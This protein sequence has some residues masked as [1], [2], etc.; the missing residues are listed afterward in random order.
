MKFTLSWLKTHLDTQADLTTLTDKLTA[1]GLEVDGVEDRAKGLEAFTVGYVKSA[2][3]H[4]DADKLRLCIVETKFGDVQVVCGAPN[5]RTGMKGVFAP[6]G[7]V[8]PGTGVEL[9]K[10]VIRGV[11]SNGMLCSMREMGLGQDHDGIIDL[12]ADAPVGAPFAQILGL[13]DPLIEIG[14]T[15]DRADCTGVRGI[16]RDLAAAGLGTLRPL[17]YAPVEGTLGASPIGL[18]FD[19]APGTESACPHFVGRYFSGI[20][21]GPSPQWLQDRLLSIGLRPI[22][23]L[24]DITNFLTFDLGRP[25]HVFDADKLSGTVHVRLARAGETL[26]A[27]DGREYTLDTEMTVVADDSGPVGIGGI[28]G[29]EATGVSENTTA[30]FLEIAYFDAVRTALTGRKL[31]ILSDARYRFERGADPEFLHAGADIASRLILDLC[32]GEASYMVEIGATPQTHRT[33]ALRPSRCLTLGGLDVPVARQIDIL[34]ALGF[35]VTTADDGVLQVS[36]PSWRGDVQGE[37]DLVE[38]V[39]RVIGF[40]S[41]PATPLKTTAALSGPAVDTRQRRAVIG[42][43]LLA[44][45]GMLEAVTWSF[46]KADHAALFRAVPEGLRLLNPI[47]ADLDVMRPTPLGNLIGAAGRNAD[48]GFADVA[49]FE[50]GPQFET[51][52]PEGQ[53]T[54]AAGIRA[55][56]AVGRGWALPAR[57]VDAFDAKADVLALLEAIGAPVDKAQTTLDAPGYYHPGRSAVLR[58]GATVLAQFGEIH[59]AV[60]KGLDA[61]GPMVAFEVFLDAIPLP[62]SRTLTRPLLKPAA[63]QPL[64]RDFAFIVDA[65]VAAEKLVRAARAADKALIVDAQVFDIYVGKGVDDGKKSVALTITLQP[66]QAALTDAQLQTVTDKVVANVAKQAGGVLR[67]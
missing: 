30:V 14:L 32:G 13:D 55:G 47:S 12:P 39:L 28:M 53:K 66:T 7:S 38:E 49:L 25:A 19:F 31:G 2:T 37:P 62:R 5:A 21:N 16:A 45:R 34:T 56:L 51:A 6:A 63:F 64:N 15:P 24:V 54:V 8:I 40:D 4:P 36:P 29:G 9:K 57:A 17:P 50:V 1:L 20:K 61:K 43:R 22:S 11:E 26:L 10:G 18:D 41:V 27:L 52:Q 35:G 33:Y 67:G 48:R 44:G 58:L 42:K 65:D 3:K 60:L 46:M 59:P 23:V